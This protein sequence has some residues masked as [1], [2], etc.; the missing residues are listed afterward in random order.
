MS[1]PPRAVWNRLDPRL[2]DTI[3]NELLTVFE[4]VIH[5]YMPYA[6]GV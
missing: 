6:K 1:I 3:I 4:E 5:Q 2:Q